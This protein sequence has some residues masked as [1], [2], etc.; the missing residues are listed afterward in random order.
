MHGK[1]V[2]RVKE[3]AGGEITGFRGRM[4]AIS[5]V[6]GPCS[7]YLKHTRREHF[8]L[9]VLRGDMLQGELTLLIYERKMTLGSK[10]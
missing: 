2:N 7:T 1:H 3:H 6:E 9:P 4:E 8:F 10:F 5:L